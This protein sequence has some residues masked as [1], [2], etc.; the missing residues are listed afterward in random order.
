MS[1]KNKTK[2]TT[3]KKNK[4]KQNKKTKTVNLDLIC[5]IPQ[6]KSDTCITKLGM[7]APRNDKIF[8]NYHVVYSV[9][10]LNLYQNRFKSRSRSR[11]DV[12]SHGRRGFE[13]NISLIYV[14]SEK[15]IK[16]MSLTLK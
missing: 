15:D 1:L 16:I 11:V 5:D 4:T 10:D 13:K 6:A 7:Y 3:K 14:I 12:E 9:Y 2:K 8:F